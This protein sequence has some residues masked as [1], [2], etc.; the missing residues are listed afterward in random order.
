MPKECQSVLRYQS[1]SS[2]FLQ[3]THDAPEHVR[4]RKER[5][6]HDPGQWN[7]VLRVDSEH[8]NA[9]DGDGLN[10]VLQWIL[11]LEVVV[12]IVSH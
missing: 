9:L 2:I 6:V 4:I 5:H 10:D 1:A 12:G 7:P 3:L 11:R 8:R